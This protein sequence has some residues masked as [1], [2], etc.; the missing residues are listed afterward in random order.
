MKKQK[1]IEGENIFLRPFN[2]NDVN[3][4]ME[5]MKDKEISE[6]TLNIPYP[7]HKSDAI[8][9]INT[10]QDKLSKDNGVIYAIID[11]KDNLIGAIELNNSV[12]FKGSAELGYWIGKAYWGKGYATKASKMIIN[13]GFE[14]MNLN[15]IYAI[16]LKS[17]IGSSR[18]MEKSGMIKE[19]DFREADF[20]KDQFENIVQYAIL[21]SDLK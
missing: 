11:Y 17:N 19:G 18:V 2:Q 3:N 5:I 21:K 4:I 9:W 6:K 14:E 15:R 1:L 20:R 16:C 10:H 12:K 13:Y 7:Y 8:S